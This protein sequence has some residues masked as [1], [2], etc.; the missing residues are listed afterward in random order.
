VRQGSAK[1]SRLSDCCREVPGS[2]TVAW[3][4]VHVVHVNIWSSV[5]WA[6]AVYAC[7]NHARINSYICGVRAVDKQVRRAA[8]RRARTLLLDLSRDFLASGSTTDCLV[9]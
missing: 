5:R 7:V 1:N 8:L 3:L 6:Y 4:P 2:N 9:G